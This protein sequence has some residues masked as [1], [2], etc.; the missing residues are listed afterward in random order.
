MNTGLVSAACLKIFKVS[1]AF[2]F[3]LHFS[4][5]DWLEA[6]SAGWLDVLPFF[7]DGCII[8]RFN[9]KPVFKAF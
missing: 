4:P 8:V 3:D 1:L 6:G 2:T 9:I 5:L 7:V